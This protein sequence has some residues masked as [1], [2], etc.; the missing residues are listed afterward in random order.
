ML[1]PIKTLKNY[2]MRKGRLDREETPESWSHNE[3]VL[4]QLW[5]D[6]TW[7]RSA[8]PN[9]T[10]GDKVWSDRKGKLHRQ[11]AEEQKASYLA[12]MQKDFDNAARGVILDSFGLEEEDRIT[13]DWPHLKGR[14]QYLAMTTIPFGWRPSYTVLKRLTER[15]AILAENIDYIADRLRQMGNLRA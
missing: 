3:K 12:S 6:G 4:R 5:P 7:Q 9:I 14:V 8:K 15:T 11:T 10:F 1:K 2:V 13:A